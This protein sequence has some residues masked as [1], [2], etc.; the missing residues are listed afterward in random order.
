[1]QLLQKL[2]ITCISEGIYVEK[3]NKHFIAIILGIV[4]IICASSVTSYFI[5][6]ANSTDSDRVERNTEQQRELLARIR[7]YQQ[8]EEDRTRREAERITAERA[9]IERTEAAI[10]AIRQSD[11]RS[12]DLLQELEAEVDILE[13]YFRDSCSQFND[14]TDNNGNE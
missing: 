8:R 12:G 6:R 7:E 3:I 10:G 9:R 4:L 2:N 1:M 14:N 5:G 11:R 13:S